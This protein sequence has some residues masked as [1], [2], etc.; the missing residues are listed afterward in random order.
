MELFKKLFYTGVGLVSTTAE[1]LQSQIDDLVKQGNLSKDEGR[2]VVDEFINT[3]EAKK[4][5]FETKIK[6]MVAKALEA[7]NL[8]TAAELKELVN[9]IEKLE[10]NLAASA[11]KTTKRTTT[12]AKKATTTAKKTVAKAKATATKVAKKV[13]DAKDA[14]V[15]TL[16]K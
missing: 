12:R 9:R 14:A 2:K 8:P 6:D 1:K 10:D 5:E 3:T 4:E 15:E 13:E 7:V 16:K 11:K